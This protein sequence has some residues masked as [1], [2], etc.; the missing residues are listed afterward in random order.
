[1][2]PLRAAAEQLP[3]QAA[4]LDL[5]TAFNCVHHFA[6][7]S[8]TRGRSGAA[9]SP[10][11]LSTSSACTARPRSA[12]PS[13]GPAGSRWSPHRPSG[14]RARARPSGSGPRP[15]D[16]TTRRSPSILRRSS[17]RP[18]RPSSP[19]CPVPRRPGLTSTCWS[20]PAG[21]AATRRSLTV[22]PAR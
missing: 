2:V 15:K 3:L 13:G 11:S 9:T 20:S 10:V 19:A 1:V 21:A 18:S 12:M 14:I 8:R 22:R 17:A 5:V 7:R 16:A 6:P 4:S